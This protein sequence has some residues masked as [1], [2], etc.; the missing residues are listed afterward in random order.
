MQCGLQE[1]FFQKNLQAV[2]AKQGEYSR[3]NPID[4]T[5]EAIELVNPED[6]PPLGPLVIRE[7]IYFLRV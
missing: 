4:L 6:Y 2:K 1:S 3:G 7:L 5:Q